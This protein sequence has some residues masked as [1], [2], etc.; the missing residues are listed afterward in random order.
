LTPL[1]PAGPLLVV[2]A[3]SAVGIAESRTILDGTAIAEAGTRAVTLWA[4]LGSANK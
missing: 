1:P 2:C 4:P 3:W